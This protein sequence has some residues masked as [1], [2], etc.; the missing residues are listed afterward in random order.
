MT[1][2]PSEQTFPSTQTNKQVVPF[3]FKFST[4]KKHIILLPANMMKHVLAEL[5]LI[6]RKKNSL[7]S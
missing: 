7:T 6:Y 2:I 3:F 5:D 1:K 4:T